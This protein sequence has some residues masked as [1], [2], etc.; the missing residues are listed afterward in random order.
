MSRFLLTLLLL[1]ALHLYGQ[2]TITD[3]YFPVAGDTLRYSVA[4]PGTSV[5]LL[6]A[7]ADRQWDFGTLTA[8]SELDLA[9]A[10]PVD[11]TVFTQADLALDI[12]STTVGYYSVTAGSLDLVGIRGTNPL[13][14]GYEIEARL[15]PSRP[16]RRAPLA[17]QNSYASMATNVVAVAA[18][19]LPAETRSEY[20]VL[21]TGVD[22]I[23]LTTISDRDD[24]VDA[25]GTLLLNGKSYEVLREKRVEVVTTQ[26]EVK[27]GA[28]DY[29]DITGLLQTFAP[30]YAAFLGEQ[31][32]VTTYY[33]WSPGQKEAVATVTE[34]EDGSVSRMT[35]VRSDATSSTGGPFLRQA[36]ISIYPNPAY[37]LTTFEVSG[38]DNGEYTISVFNV[39][40]RRVA[41]T[42]FS[43]SL[44]NA[45]VP[46]EL[47]NL[48][49]GTYLYSLMN[50]RGRILTTRRVMVGG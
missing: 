35:F 39:L 1:P 41:T 21:L 34:E 11:E 18:S 24:S 45:K 43:P 38:L 15:S 31:A 49:R 7:G 47:D 14:P 44:G 2:V 37:G 36:S 48:P 10:T 30:E 19:E 13:L 20:G 26:V 6:T 29:S 50:Q 16:E 33:F 12:D 25:Y 40:G 5:D 17:Y 23:R 9:A 22:S 8:A 3:A 46:V 27:S 32:P 4:E 28:L 42:T